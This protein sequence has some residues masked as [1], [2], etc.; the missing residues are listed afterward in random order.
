MGELKLIIDRGQ[1][2]VRVQELARAIR[3]DYNEKAP[4]L[5]G[6]L[7]GAFVFLADLVRELGMPVIVDFVGLSTY[8]LRQ[9]SEG[10]VTVTYPLRV[11][12]KGQDVLVV[13]D[14]VDSGVTIRFL[15]QY[16]ANKGAAT[17]RVCALLARTTGDAEGL[18]DYVG[19]TVGEGWVVGYGIDSGERYR[20]LPEIYVLEEGQG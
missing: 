15:R 4:I 6:V 9:T 13:E 18:A 11:E 5:I 3:T 10:A 12:I 14:I 7:K 20:Y 1:I 19:F 16:L 2:A 17:V 8:G